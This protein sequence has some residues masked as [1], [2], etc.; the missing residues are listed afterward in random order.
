[1]WVANTGVDIKQHLEERM[2]RWMVVML[3]RRVTQNGVTEA[4]LWKIARRMVDLLVWK[5]RQAVA[6][7]LAAGNPPPPV[8]AFIP[9]TTIQELLTEELL[10]EQPPLNFATR[11]VI[12]ALFQE[13]LQSIGGPLPLCPTNFGRGRRGAAGEGYVFSDRT[14]IVTS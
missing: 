4:R 13:T 12:G 11:E 3:G 10:Y 9:P 1:M 7:A 6:A 2:R 5:E 8:P 14:A